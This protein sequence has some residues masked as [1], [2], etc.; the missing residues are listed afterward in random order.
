MASDF[1][2]IVVGSGISGGWAAKE[3]AERGLKVLLL[4]RGRNVRHRQDY[5]TEGKGNWELPY[6]GQIPEAEEASDYAVQ[7]SCYAFNDFTKHFF[8]NDRENPYGTP[9]GKPFSWIRGYHL[10]GRSL[11]WHRQCYRWS[12]IDFEA[13]LKDGHG[14]DW[15]IRYRD[16]APWYDYVEEFAGISGSI[17]GLPQL[18]DGKFQPAFEMN[19]VE[20]DVKARMEARFPERNLIIGRAAHLTAPTDDQKAL[21]RGQCMNRNECQRGCSFGAY[22]SSLSATLP[23]ANRTGNLETVTDAIVT[24]VN[25]D[26]QERR[27]TGVNVINANTKQGSSFTG[28]MVFLCAS[29]LGTAQI[30]LNSSSESFP[31]G[32]ANSSGTLG[33]FLMDHIGGSTSTGLFD[34]HSDKYHSP[35]RPNECYVPRFRNVEE[36]D[37]RFL[38]GFGYQGGAKRLDWQRGTARAGIGA[39]LKAELRQPGPWQFSIEG[40]GEMLPDERNRV[41]LDERRKDEW[42]IPILHIDCE[43]RDNEKAM[44]QVMAEDAGEMMKAAGL[45]NIRTQAQLAPPGLLIHE[46]G[47]ARMGRD[48]ATS[49]L[50]EHNQAHDIPNLFVTDGAAM[51]SSACQNPSLTYMALTARA[52]ATAVQMLSDGTI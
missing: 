13:N 22:F 36:Q 25:Y 21:G 49:V 47:T 35:R 34:G 14:V 4:E 48:S 19:C 28:R 15:P 32:I 42:G 33:R 9:E 12:D 26:P 46:M 17:E 1:D 5:V 27:V 8:V 52:S 11:Q 2:A 40:F 7:K 16:I 37:D 45:S 31:N 10:G 39:D 51:T 43:H 18:P 20:K 38:R 23:A 29:T 50:N 3:L 24:S 41:W 30:M 44:I 6:R